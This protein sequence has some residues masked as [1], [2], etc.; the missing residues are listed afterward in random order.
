MRAFTVLV[1]AVL[2]IVLLVAPAQAAGPQHPGDFTGYAFDT[3]DAPSQKKMNDWRRASRYAG[4]GVYI[5]G[6]NR[7]CKAQPHLTRTWVNKQERKGWRLLPLVVGRQASCAPHGRYVGKRISDRPA[8]GYA[9]ARAQGR[10]AARRAVSAAR[11]LGIAKRSVLWF[12]LEH[13]DTGVKR[14]RLSALSFTSGWTMGLHQR[15]YRSGFYS[16]AS[17]GIAMLDDARRNR[18]RKYALPDYL[19]VAEWNGQDTVRSSYISQQGWWPNRRVHQYRGPRTE[20]HAGSRINVD[21]NFLSTGRGTRAGKAG[22]PCMV[23]VDFPSYRRLERGDRGPRVAAAQC[24]LKQDRHYRGRLHGRYDKA[25]SRAVRSFQRH[26]AGVSTSG[27]VT[28]RTWT[29]L[30][31]HGG[32]P[33]VKYGAG[34]KAVRRLQR[35][36]N[37]ATDAAL[38]IDGTFGK[39]ELR[40]VKGYQR[41]SGRADT[42][43][44]TPATWRLLRHGRTVGRL[45]SPAELEISE[46]L[47]GLGLLADIPFSSGAVRD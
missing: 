36:L 18:P 15:G 37:A 21:S 32:D 47:E 25:T 5:A 29:S 10:D 27:A 24:L 6:M 41:Q 40:A 38:D 44:V 7:A 39:P 4:V 11:R 16:S 28:A 35:A 12:D 1:A 31:S 2:G 19:W 42:G 8:R 43:V 20:N 45:A 13:F 9:A 34:G 23:R 17:S 3:C 14:C 22:G 30:L 46:L 33:L 26:Q